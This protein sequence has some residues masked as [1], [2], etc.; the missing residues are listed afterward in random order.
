MVA[1]LVGFFA[2]AGLTDPP[3]PGPSAA[4]ALSRAPST[5]FGCVEDEDA[6]DTVSAFD[7][8][9]GRQPI[10]SAETTSAVKTSAVKT[11]ALD[12]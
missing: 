2:L 10:A 5:T 1:R 9:A 3:P 4:D 8:A 7:C 12:G 6:A 11:S